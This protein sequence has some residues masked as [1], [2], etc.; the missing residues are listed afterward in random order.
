M[1]ITYAEANHILSA[2]IPYQRVD[3]H[4]THHGN[5]PYILPNLMQTYA[6][7]RI[8]KSEPDFQ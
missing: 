3:L 5:V 1:K 6:S 8:I 4:T 2:L 7:C